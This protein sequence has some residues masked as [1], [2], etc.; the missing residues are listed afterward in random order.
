RE[1]RRRLALHSAAAISRGNR[2]FPVDVNCD[3]YLTLRIRFPRRPGYFSNGARAF[4]HFAVRF[5]PTKFGLP[6]IADF[7]CFGKDEVL[8]W[9]AKF[10]VPGEGKR[11][12]RSQDRRCRVTVAV[13]VWGLINLLVQ[14]RLKRVKPRRQSDE[15]ARV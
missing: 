1:G 6:L 4:N 13:Q 5:G 7:H 2:R 3:R 8:S 12:L 9:V 10:A 14:G 15:V 11:Q